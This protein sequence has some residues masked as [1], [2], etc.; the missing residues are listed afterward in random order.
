MQTIDKWLWGEAEIKLCVISIWM[1]AET[2]SVDDL[3]KKGA[4]MALLR[5]LRVCLGG[6]H[7]NTDSKLVSTVLISTAWKMC[8][9]NVCYRQC[10]I[11]ST[12]SRVQGEEWTRPRGASL[13][14]QSDLWSQLQ[15]W[16]WPLAAARKNEIAELPGCLQVKIRSR[17]N[18]CTSCW[19]VMWYND[20]KSFKGS[21]DEKHEGLHSADTWEHLKS[22]QVK[23]SCVLY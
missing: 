10:F 5:H 1:E 17:A 14:L 12:R 15:P 22:K 3:T 23:I 19:K 18:R 11:S 7:C 13:I 6:I 21:S 8:P 16:S 9:A 4:C 20:M 2:T